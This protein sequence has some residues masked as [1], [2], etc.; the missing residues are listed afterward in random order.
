MRNAWL[1]FLVAACCLNA[2]AAETANITFYLIESSMQTTSGR[3][4]PGTVTLVRR[5]VDRAAGRIEE[6]VISLRGSAPAQ[7][8]IS[9][10]KPEGSKATISCSN[11]DLEGEGEF[12]G[13]PWEWSGF[14]FVTRI[15]KLGQRVEGEDHFFRGGMSADKKVIGADGR[16]TAVIKES[17][18]TIAPATY[19]LLRSRLLPA[20]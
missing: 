11:C 20:K 13:E 15:P 9:V 14:K 4:L 12:S 18:R 19:E 1:A 5:E 10:I 2:E 6:S 17:G 8:F 16:T 3:E 7:E